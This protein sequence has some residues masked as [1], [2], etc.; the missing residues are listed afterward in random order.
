MFA[1]T[2]GVPGGGPGNAVDL[3]HLSGQSEAAS[4]S[5]SALP[6]NVGGVNSH[7][8]QL[9]VD[10]TKVKQRFNA[11]GAMRRNNSAGAAQFRPAA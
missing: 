2:R 8:R 3:V 5:S 4:S 11:S 6:V 9:Q 10:I 1:P 7:A